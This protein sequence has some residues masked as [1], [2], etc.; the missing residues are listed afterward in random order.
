MA[1][2]SPSEAR[3]VAALK[4]HD[5]LALIAEWAANGVALNAPDPAR[6]ATYAAKEAAIS[7]DHSA[8]LALA[9]RTGV[10]PDWDSCLSAPVQSVMR[11]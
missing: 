8:D 4:S 3:V 6:T 9:L 1:Y 7:A 2:T 5:F 11:K 10:C